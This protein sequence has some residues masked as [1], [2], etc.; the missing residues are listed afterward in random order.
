MPMKKC[1]VRKTRSKDGKVEM[2]MKL[3]PGYMLRNVAGYNVVVPIGE[4]ALDFNGMINL[5]ESGAMLWTMLE[6]DTT[7]EDMTKA[8]LD[9]YETT[10]E[11]ARA[12]VSLFIKKMREANLIDE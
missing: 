9:E 5:N 11:I 3:K 12:D 6:N 4:A 2:F 10:E 7:E 1:V 8:L